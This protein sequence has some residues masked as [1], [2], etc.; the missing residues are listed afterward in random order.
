MEGEREEEE[1][2]EEDKGKGLEERM[3]TMPRRIM[4]KLAPG[5][6]TIYVPHL[7]DYDG[8]EIRR[9]VGDYIDQDGDDDDGDALGSALHGAACCGRWRYAPHRLIYKEAGEEAG[10]EALALRAAYV[11][12]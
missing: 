10:E 3:R 6:G 11:A 4:N 9:N 5:D 8:D 1:Y 2:A 12:C 7:S